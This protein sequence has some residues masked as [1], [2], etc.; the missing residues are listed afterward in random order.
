MDATR[1]RILSAAYR[2]FSA[3]GFRGA[4]TRRISAEAGV[5]EVTV[6]RHFASKEQ[7]LAAALDWHAAISIAAIDAR[8][9]PGE[10]AAL[11]AELTSFLLGTLAGFLES[12]Q[13]VRTSL[14][15]WGHHPD[16][17]ES[18]MLTTNHV[19]DM[20]E[21]YL[22]AAR[23][24]GLIRPD[25]NIVVAAELML[26]TVFADGMLRQVLPRRFPLDPAASVAA[27]LDLV[28]DGLAPA[29]V[30]AREDS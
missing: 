15:E 20:L 10:P 2:I 5:N 4:M 9:L 8:P 25:A 29:A 11:R 22:A 12:H 27:Y 3:E 30:L 14:G 7:M 28:L 16:L 6:F 13:A 26:A 23:A 18:L 19:Y 1:Q 21:R 24:A 17:D